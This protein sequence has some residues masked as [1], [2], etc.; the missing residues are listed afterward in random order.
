[1]FDFFLLVVV[2][3]VAIWAMRNWSVVKGWFTA[4]EK[5]ATPP[6]EPPT[7]DSSSDNSAPPGNAPPTA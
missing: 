5:S 2:A 1:M 3:L 6:V 7:S 4:V